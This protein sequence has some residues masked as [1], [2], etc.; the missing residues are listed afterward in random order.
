MATALLGAVAVAFGQTVQTN[1]DLTF[2]K[3]ATSD[4]AGTATVS[5]LGTRT[6]SGGAMPVTSSFTR[7]SFTISGTPNVTFAILLPTSEPLINGTAGLTVDT[8]QSLP[9]GTGTFDGSGSRDLFVGATLHLAANQARG[10]YSGSFEVTVT[11]N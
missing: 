4:T 11:Y 1:T 7:A 9:S 2:G 5:P 6:S 3:I 8:F 10:A